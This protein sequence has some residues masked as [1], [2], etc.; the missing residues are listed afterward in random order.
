[1]SHQVTQTRVLKDSVKKI[2]V[3]AA[4]IGISHPEAVDVALNEAIAARRLQ[5][6][7]TDAARDAAA[8][9]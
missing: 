4:S 7:A 9:G 8:T 3:L 6:P 2:R 5:V 1:M